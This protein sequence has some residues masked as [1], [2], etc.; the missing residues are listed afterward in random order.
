MIRQLAEVGQVN[1]I[2]PDE[3]RARV[4][5]R[6]KKVPWDQAVEVILEAQGLWYEYT[7]DGNIMR[8]ASRKQ[9]DHEFYAAVERARFE[10]EHLHLID[11]PRAP[12]GETVDLDFKDA[13]IHHIMRLLS[14]VGSVNIVI[15]DHIRA[16]VTIRMKG[17]AWNRAMETILQ[18]KGLW[19]RYRE[20]GKVIRIASRKPLDAEDYAEVERV[21]ERNK[22]Q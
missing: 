20:N 16:R 8:I 14:D 21:R 1:A 3:V 2:V 12:G 13:D 4:T 5:V 11:H 7:E 9:L 18:A 6:M 15:P 19:Y 22:H 17:V 10:A